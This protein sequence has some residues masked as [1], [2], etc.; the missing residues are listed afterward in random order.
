MKQWQLNEK[1]EKN[2]TAMSELVLVTGT[3]DSERTPRDS[4]LRTRDLE[5]K[6]KRN[7]ERGTRE[8]TT[9]TISS[10]FPCF[11]FYFT[12]NAF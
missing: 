1:R 7:V 8:H 3:Q 9:V 10:S 2:V 12:L 6:K 11:I 4:E 5:R